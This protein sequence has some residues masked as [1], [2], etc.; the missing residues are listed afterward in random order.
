[1]RVSAP[2]PAAPVLQAQDVSV[3]LGGLPVLRGV[4]L[5]V[6]PGEAVALLGGN[7]SGKSTLVRALLGLTPLSRGSVQLFGT[8]L[9]R[10]RSWARVGYVPQRSTAGFNGAKVREVVA[11]G[12]LAH[13]RPFVPPRA[14]DRDAVARALRAVDLSER[15]GEDLAVLSGGQQQRVL[16]ARALAGDPELLVLD[17]PTAGVDLAHQEVLT[18]V[19]ADLVATG[20]AV[21]VVL[22]DIGSLGDLVGR[23]VVLREGRVAVDAPMADLV[24]GH[25]HGDAGHHEPDPGLSPWLDGTVGR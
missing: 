15:A 1:L 24:H 9:R 7:G 23:G 8:P 18:A 16:I 12:R 19:L 11:S 6:R 21:L 5:T 3:E 2:G 22:H 14:S 20:T 10:F 13:R 25:G 17:E 4:D